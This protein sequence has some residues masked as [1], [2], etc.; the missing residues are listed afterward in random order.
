MTTPVRRSGFVAIGLLLLLCAAARA[1]DTATAPIDWQRARTLHQKAEQGETLTAEEQAYLDRATA[2]RGAG[3]GGSGIASVLNQLPPEEQQQVRALMQ[4]RRAGEALTEAD[5]ALQAK[6]Q[7]LLAAQSKTTPVDRDTSSQSPRDHT[8]LVPLNEMTADQQ[9]HG[10]DGG[11]YG[12]GRNDPPPAHAQAALAEAMRIVPLDAVGKPVDSAKSGGKIALLSVGMSNTTQEFSRFVEFAQRDTAK[13]SNVVLVDGAQGGK[14]AA[15]WAVSADN[16]VWRTV[17]ARL[18]AA[19][20]TDQQV[21][22]A[23]LKQA[24]IRPTEAFPKDAEKLAADTATIIRMLKVRFPNLRIIYLSSRIYAGYATTALNP[25]PYAYDGAYAVRDLIQRQIAGEP[26]LNYDLARGAVKAPLLLWGPYL[27]ADG[28]TPRKSDGLIWRREDLR[29]DGT[30]PSAT[31]GRDKVANMLLAFLK[32]D[33][34][35]KVWFT[36]K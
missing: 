11:L 19:G 21:Q 23:W 22:V 5:R 2:A 9:Y 29:E 25:E 31:S 28:L 16:E 36:P 10:R 1:A 14:A 17:T 20:V 32:T 7:R 34:T 27:W 4:K 15:Q 13:A 26:E 30:H 8:G 24:E 18:K 3:S 35:A 12:G 33:P 6:V